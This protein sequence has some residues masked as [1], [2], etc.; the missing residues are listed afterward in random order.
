MAVEAIM[1][2]KGFRTVMPFYVI[3]GKFLQNVKR[4]YS[5]SEAKSKY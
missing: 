3:F 5:A 4:Q 1:Q 2:S